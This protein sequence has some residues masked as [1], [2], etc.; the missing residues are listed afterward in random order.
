MKKIAISITIAW[1][2]LQPLCGQTTV[3]H[4]QVNDWFKVPE[5]GKEVKDSPIKEMLWRAD[6]PRTS[7]NFRFQKHVSSREYLDC[8]YYKYV[9]CEDIR[10]CRCW[11]CKAYYYDFEIK[12]SEFRNSEW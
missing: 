2:L 7:G 6:K 11:Q 9:N 8:S 3:L 12:D 10:F 4:A 5:H 1:T